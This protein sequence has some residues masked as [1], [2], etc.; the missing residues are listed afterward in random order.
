MS[1][2]NLLCSHDVRNRVSLCTICV[3]NSRDEAKKQGAKEELEKVLN[4]MVTLD[5]ADAHNLSEAFNEE[6]E[7]I[8]K[9]LKEL[10]E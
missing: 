1:E 3:S 2:M 8:K 5:Y 10:G 6:E 4:R 9:R 7:I